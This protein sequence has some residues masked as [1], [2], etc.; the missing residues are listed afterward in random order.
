M[1]VIIK[2][3]NYAALMTEVYEKIGEGWK[4][5]KRGKKK[6]VWLLESSFNKIRPEP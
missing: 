6:L 2:S 3:W 5:K 4:V 1:K